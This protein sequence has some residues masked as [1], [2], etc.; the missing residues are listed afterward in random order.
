MSYGFTD[1][2]TIGIGVVPLFLF[3]GTASPVWITP[4]VS[5]PVV[6]DQFNVGVGA[7]VGTVIGDNEN[8]GGFGLI[9]GN[10]TFGPREKNITLGLGYGFAYGEWSQYPTF[11]VSGMSRVGKKFA[12]ISENYFI[13]AGGETVALLSAGGRF[14]GRKV[15]IDA[16]LVAPFAS[17]QDFFFAFP[18]LGINVPFS[19]KK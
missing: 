19:K 17:E 4:K 5:I 12:F 8:S 9:Y 6:K 16:A 11:S 7:F 1:N 18:W 2:L 15:S 10:T 13:S 3:G 14:I